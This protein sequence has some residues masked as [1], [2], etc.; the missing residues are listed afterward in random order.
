MCHQ[1]RAFDYKSVV[2]SHFKFKPPFKNKIKCKNLFY[3]Y[4]VKCQIITITVLPACPGHDLNFRLYLEIEQTSFFT[5]LTR[6]G[7]WQVDYW[8]YFNMY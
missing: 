8:R 3:K 7:R 5:I 1:H 6:I 4:R 2:K